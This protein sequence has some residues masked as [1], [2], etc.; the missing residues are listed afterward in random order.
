MTFQVA[1]GVKK[2]TRLPL[3]ETQE[4]WD[5]SLGWE[6][7][8]GGGHGNP[9]QYSCLENPM[10]GG[11]LQTTVHRVAKSWIQ[12]KQLRTHTFNGILSAA[13]TRIPNSK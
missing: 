11:A 7:P 2:K 13:N 4:M 8:P 10:D 1:L 12:L 9:L 6:D 3:Q 5:Q